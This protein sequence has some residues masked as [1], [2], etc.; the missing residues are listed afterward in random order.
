MTNYDL[1]RGLRRLTLPVSRWLVRFPGRAPI[2]GFLLLIG[3]GTLL[4]MLPAASADA[5]IGFIDAL[6]TATSAGCVTG[7]IVMD[8]GTAFSGFGE[9]VILLLIQ[10]GGLGIMTISTLFLMIAGRRTGLMGRMVIHDTFTQKRNLN[11]GD[12]V[13]NVILMAC[14]LELIGAV[15]LFFCFLPDHGAGRAVYLAVFHAVSAFCNAGFSLFPDSLMGYAEHWVV[16]LTVCFLIIAGGIG[17]L[18]LSELKRMFPFGKRSW[19]R[20]SLHSKLVISTSLILWG[21]G[22]LLFLM[23]EWHNTLAPLSIPDRFLAAFFQSVTTRTAGF[24]TLAIE[25]L[26]SGALFL[27]IVFMFIGACP[28]SC[29]GGVKTTTVGSLFLLGISRLR[30]HKF[31][32]IF[33][34][35]IPMTSVWRAI[36]VVMLSTGIIVFSLMLLLAGELGALSPALSRSGFLDLFFEAV[37][38]FGTVG[39]STGVTGGLTPFGKLVIT[40]EMF[41]GR[42]GPLVIGIAISRQI[43]SR[44]HYAEEEIMIG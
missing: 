28:G 39:L 4:L 8:T 19:S 37:S 18:V 13:R 29:G 24:N 14:S 5:P 38:A 31:P 26:S 32:R 10:T 21:A 44:Y 16:N 15:I 23:M 11:P 6:F 20:L 27:I 9:G 25:N 34:R 12:I 3:I 2:L 36:N 42:L 43:N 17:F 30:G 1:V 35:T 41:I 40:A 7:L 22:T 33:Y